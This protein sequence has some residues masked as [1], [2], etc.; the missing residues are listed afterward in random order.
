MK[1]KKGN[2]G[3]EHFLFVKL[4]P[5]NKDPRGYTVLTLT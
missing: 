3:S 4:D 1:K 5:N 2:T